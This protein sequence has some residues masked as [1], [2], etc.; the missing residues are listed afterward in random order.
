MP[1]LKKFR[2]FFIEQHYRFQLG[3]QFLIFVNFALLVITASDKLKKVLPIDYTGELV[4]LSIL[5]AFLGAWLFGLILEKFVKYPQQQERAAVD[6]S[7]NWQATHQKLDTIIE[8]LDKL[9]RKK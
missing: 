6:R 3:M 4:L 2:D 9:E 5:L 1:M 8:R 7:P